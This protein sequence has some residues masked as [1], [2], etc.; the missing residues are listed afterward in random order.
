MFLETPKRQ[1]QP[2]L[3]VSAIVPYA[4][5]LH[6]QAWIYFCFFVLHCSLHPNS[7]LLNQRKSITEALKKIIIKPKGKK[8]SHNLYHFLCPCWLNEKPNRRRRCVAASAAGQ[9]RGSVELGW[10]CV[11][12]PAT[13]L[14]LI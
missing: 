5:A 11:F 10:S 1:T 12:L 2:S 3:K 8:K 4:L 6:S 14:S 7:S 9:R 13:M